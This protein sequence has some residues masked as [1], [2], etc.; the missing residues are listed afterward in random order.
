M[1]VSGSGK[2]T[3]ALALATQIGA[4]FCDADWLHP[5]D[6]LAKMST[7]QALGDEERW[8]WLHTVGQHMKRFESNRRSSVTACSALK[9][10]YR[11]VL[12]EYVPDAFFVF[13]DGP[14]EVIQARID[15]RSHEF[16]PPSLVA[17]QFETLEPLD[18]DERGM[19]VDIELDPDEIV[20]K[21]EAE[22][23]RLIIA[24]ELNDEEMQ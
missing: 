1:G 17:S 24:I 2:S 9:Q 13:L 19:R 21:I 10:S 8:P 6:N 15:T 20:S 7:G 14:F 18:D 23:K 16:M 5:A 11:D 4:E 22:L 3:I 12:R